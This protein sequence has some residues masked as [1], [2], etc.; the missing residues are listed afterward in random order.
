M[1]NPKRWYKQPRWVRVR[2]EALHIHKY[3]CARCKIDLRDAGKQAQVHHRIP[4]ERAPHRGFDLFNLE[5]LC[6]RCHNKEHG[7]GN[8]SGAYGCS[9]DGT[10]R[11]PDHPWNISTGGDG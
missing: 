6:I 4:L 1:A 10:P 5:P 2:N 8:R 11:D 9:V 7:R 3:R